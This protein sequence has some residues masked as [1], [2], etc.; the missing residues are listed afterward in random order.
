MSLAGWLQYF[1][2]LPPHLAR[3]IKR[4]STTEVRLELSSRISVISS[5][6]TSPTTRTERTGPS[7]PI[8]T[9]RTTSRPPCAASVATGASAASASSSIKRRLS[10]AGG[11][12]VSCMRSSPRPE[13]SPCRIGCAFRKLTPTKRKRPVLSERFPRSL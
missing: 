4:V 6:G 5:I 12:S 2:S 10:S 11:A 13:S 8:A 1:G 7:Q 9:S 3:T